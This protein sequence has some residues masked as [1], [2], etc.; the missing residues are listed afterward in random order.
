MALIVKI[1]VNE[2]EIIETHAVRVKG[3]PHELCTYRLPDGAL[4]THHYDKG[5]VPLA[6]MMLE[7]LETKGARDERSNM[8][9]WEE[10]CN[11]ALD[12]QLGV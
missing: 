11:G 10:D 12:L 7:A 4:I 1:F 3:Q 8:G 6:V 5:A 2:R 9:K